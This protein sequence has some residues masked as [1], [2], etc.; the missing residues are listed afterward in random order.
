[1][2]RGRKRSRETAGMIAAC[3]GRE[4]ALIDRTFAWKTETRNKTKKLH[5]NQ[6]K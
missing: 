5:K 4:E 1:M 6:S 3:M 2:Y